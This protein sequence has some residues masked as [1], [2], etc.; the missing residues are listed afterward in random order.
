MRAW[1]WRMTTQGVWEEEIW[2][3]VGKF[4]DMIPA[5]GRYGRL[6]Y[7]GVLGTERTN[8]EMVRSYWVSFVF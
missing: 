8:Q 2:Q 7:L 3:G 1:L 4:L 6:Y 5:S